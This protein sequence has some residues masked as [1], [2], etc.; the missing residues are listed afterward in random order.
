MKKVF[1][2]F[3]AADVDQSRTLKS[4]VYQ[5]CVLWK[6]KSVSD[7]HRRLE[8]IDKQKSLLERERKS[9][10]E[11]GEKQAEQHERLAMWEAAHFCSCLK[12]IGLG[13][14][15]TEASRL[16]AYAY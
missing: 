6:L 10:V 3:R 5:A 8:H 7:V 12:C 13:F 15:V 11:R 9:M 4:D 1:R 14:D 2:K 16:N